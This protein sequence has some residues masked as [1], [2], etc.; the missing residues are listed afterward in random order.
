MIVH[1]VEFTTAAAKEIRKLDPLT[2]RRVLTAASKL[3]A[4]PRPT[5]SE[6]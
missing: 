5:E 3:E 6:S 1:T 4:D 2:R